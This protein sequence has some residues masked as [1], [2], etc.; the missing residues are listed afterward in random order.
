VS[1]LA[2]Q[3]WLRLLKTDAVRAS[4]WLYLCPIFGFLYSAILMGEPVTIYTIVGTGLVMVALYVGQK[5]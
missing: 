1:I 5:K 3:L 4:L 2:V